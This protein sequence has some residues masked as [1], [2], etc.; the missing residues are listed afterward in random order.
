MSRSGYSDDCE[1]LYL[2]RNTVERAIKGKRGQ[3]FLKELAAILDA[4]PNKRLIS[5]ELINGEEVC[6]IGA[7]CK[8]R[9]VDV[10]KIESYDPRDVGA[11]VGIATALAAEIEYIND[12][13]GDFRETPE[14]RWIRVRKWVWELTP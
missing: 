5:G 1:Y 11:A 14:Q 13:A 3:V 2:Y 12:E 6:A 4:M 10:S 8:A 7:V 9:Q